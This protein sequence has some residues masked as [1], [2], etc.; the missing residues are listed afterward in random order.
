MVV[1]TVALATKV[2]LWE[3]LVATVAAALERQLGELATAAL[4]VGLLVA[5]LAQD[6]ARSATPQQ[7]SAASVHHPDPHPTG[8]PDLASR[9]RT[10]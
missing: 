4:A 5:V 7:G 3:R 1:V 8:L 9:H 2:L 10:A 6:L